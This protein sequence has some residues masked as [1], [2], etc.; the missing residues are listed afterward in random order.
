MNFSTILFPRPWGRKHSE[1]K[2]LPSIYAHTRFAHQA[3]KTLPE[4]VQRS[5]QRFPQLF[6]VGAQGPDFFFFYQPMFKTKMGS[7]GGWF[8]NL[9][10][11]EFFERAARH[12]ADFPSEGAMVYLYGV[13]CHYALDSRCHP[14]IVSATAGK[15][16]GHT[17]LETEFD[18]VLLARDGKEPPYR[19]NL[20]RPLHLTWGECVTVSGF[21][22]PATTYTVR[23]S[24]HIMA[25][26]CRA[27]TMK[28][29]R[30]LHGI[31]SLGG[32]YGGQMVMYTR[33]NHRCTRLVAQLDGLYSQ[34]LDC[35]ASL[36]QQLRDH[37]D[38][39]S[40]L[41]ADFDANF[42]GEPEN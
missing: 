42:S 34:A 8:H 32:E 17:E 12:Y 5:I 3:A 26:V 41:G 25:A 31:L 1:V 24:L 16:P 39:G 30:L 9:S 38:N 19:Q 29:R 35:Y 21:Y 11:R 28:S 14:L 13:L 15:N 7:L 40:P 18:R 2:D 23:R 20:G 4:A 33:P 22:P 37:M 36:A 6:D 27:M 10:G